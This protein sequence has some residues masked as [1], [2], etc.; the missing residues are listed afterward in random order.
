MSIPAPPAKTDYVKA[1]KVESDDEFTKPK[2]VFTS[3]KD[4]QTTKSSKKLSTNTSNVKLEQNMDDFDSTAPALPA[5]FKISNATEFPT[6]G[7]ND[8]QVIS[9]DS[10]E[11]CW[12][13]MSDKKS[14]KKKSK[15]EKKKKEKKEKKETKSKKSKR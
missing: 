6:L 2:F 1:E 9:S 15:K 3:K 11:N 14:K 12:E 5:G 4:R 8:A 7:G 13:V 10:D